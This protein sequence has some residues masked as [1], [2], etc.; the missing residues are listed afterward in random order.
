MD[1]ERI[2]DRVKEIISTELGIEMDKVHLNSNFTQDLGV[3]SLEIMQ[4]LISLEEEFNIKIPDKD[5]ETLATVG[6]LIQYIN[7]RAKKDVF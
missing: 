7:D 6:D 2:E 1:M 3:D 5:I 4:L